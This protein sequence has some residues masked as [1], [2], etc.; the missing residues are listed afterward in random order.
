MPVY[1]KLVRDLIPQ[2]IEKSGGKFSTRTLEPAEHLTEIKNKLYEEVKE[3]Q[4][5][6]NRQDALEELADILEL[7]HAALPIHEATYEELEEIRIAKKEKRG[8]F[9]EGIYLIE[10][11]DE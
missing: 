7:I 4:E 6:N 8:G 11:E 2:V 3:F 10:V 1:N 5:T 9:E